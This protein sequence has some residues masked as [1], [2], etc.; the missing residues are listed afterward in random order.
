M[1]R[2]IATTGGPSRPASLSAV[3]KYTSGA[4]IIPIPSGSLEASFE[5]PEFA[6]PRLNKPLVLALLFNCLL[7]FGFALILRALFF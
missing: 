3:T 6:E 2:P 1:T 5:S 7:W 4:E